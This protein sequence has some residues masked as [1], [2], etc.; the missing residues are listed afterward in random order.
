[1][2][3]FD[4]LGDLAKSFGEAAIAQPRF[5]WDIAQAPFN[6]NEEYNGFK[7]TLETAANNWTQSTL[8]FVGEVTNLPGIKQT[9]ETAMVPYR[10]YVAPAV[11][12]GLLAV[13][14]N[15]RELN[16]NLSGMDLLKK[17]FEEGK[18]VR[19]P[20]TDEF[21]RQEPVD[22]WRRKISPG[23]ALIADIAALIP[24]EQGADEVNWN[25]QESIENYYGQGLP[26]FFSGASDLGFS[27]LDPTLFLG[28]ASKAIRATDV[29]TNT[30]Q[31]GNSAAAVAAAANRK[32]RAADEI[33]EAANALHIASLESQRLGQEVA[34]LVTNKYTQLIK[35][36]TA[37]DNKYAL[38]QPFMENAPHKTTI[39]YALGESNDFQLTGQILAAVGVGDK[40]ALKALQERAEFVDIGNAI[41]RAQGEVD[42]LNKYLASKGQQTSDGQMTF[43]FVHES[44]A[45]NLEAK[46]ELEALK[47]RDA[48]LT[49]L[50]EA[51][52]ISQFTRTIGSSPVRAFDKFLAETRVAK[53]KVAQQN[54]ER[55][56]FGTTVTEY[57]PTPFH[58][59]I[60]V[61]ARPLD[62]RPAGH[63]NLNESD[64]LQ[65]LA[66]TVERG[67]KLAGGSKL[68]SFDA[69]VAG[70]YID[71]Y[72]NAQTPEARSAAVKAIERQIAIK[73]AQ[74]YG[75]SLEKAI[76][77]YNKHDRGRDSALVTIR[78]DTFII[79]EDGRQIHDPWFESQSANTLP[80]MD[81]DLFDSLLKKN[82]S[83]IPLLNDLTMQTV[84]GMDFL[85]DMFKAGALIRLGYLTR[86]TAEAQ[87]R[88][89]STLGAMTSLRHLGKGINNF[90]YNTT[91]NEGQRSIDRLTR[92]GKSPELA[93]LKT[94]LKDIDDELVEVEKT[95]QKYVDKEDLQSIADAKTLSTKYQELLE[96]RD[97]T[98]ASISQLTKP[99]GKKRRL[100]EGV[101][102]YE[103]LNGKKYYL[104]E[105]FA[106]AFG[107]L[108]RAE[109]S[110]ANTLTNFL[111]AN[112]DTIGKGLIDTGT[113]VV[114]PGAPGY[115]ENWAE[116]LTRQFGNSAVAKKLA[117]GE[118]P[119]AVV[120]WLFNTPEGRRVR[121]RLENL[122]DKYDA[123]DYVARTKNFLDR[124]AP[125]PEIQ[126]TLANP[127]DFEITVDMLKNKFGQLDE[128]KLP[129]IHGRVLEE[130]LNMKG[131][132]LIRV[133]IRKSFRVLGSLPED[134]WSRN[135]VFNEFYQREYT[136]RM[137][138][139]TLGLKP[140]EYV[141][142]KQV[143]MSEQ[144]ARNYALKQ[145]KKLLFTIDRRTNAAT[146]LRWMLPF[147]S[148]YVN[149]TRTWGRILYE[150]PGIAVRGYNLVTA[151]NR[152]GI[153]YDEEG[154]IVS[155]EQAT[156]DDSIVLHIPDGMKKLPIIGKG[157]ESL[158]EMGIQK[159]S[160]DVIMQGNIGLPVGPPI[161]IAASEVVKRKPEYEDTLRW[162]IPYGP[163]RNAAMAMIPAWAK[164]Q[165][166]KGM[167][168]DSPEYANTYELIWNTEQFKRKQ[169]GLPPATET[170]IQEMTDAFYNMRTV[171]NLVLPFAPR[172]NTPYKFYIDQYRQY[173]NLY[174]MDA[175]TKFFED[176]PEFFNFSTSLSKNNTGAA[177]TV[178]AVN[179]SKKYA[180]LI[181][182][183]R[184]DD[185]KL[186]GLIANTGVT[187]DFSR[188]AY[189][190]QQSNT[191]SP[192]SS[193]TF[194]G[195]NDPVQAQKETEA[196]LG[197]IKYRK[198]MDQIDAVMA[199]R[200]LT[201][202]QSK[203][204]ADLKELKRQLV[205]QLGKENE[206]WYDDYLDS[207]G[208]KTNR[209]IRGFEKIISNE[210]FM[211]DHGDN[212]TWKSLAI[213]LNVRRQVSDALVARGGT[214]ITNKQNA[215]LA[216]L[217]QD[218]ANQLKQQDIGFG[219]IYDRYLDS[220]R[221][222][223]VVYSTKVAE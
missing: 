108:Y 107:D 214:S 5:I 72:V 1:M 141:S 161:A 54:A 179:N 99:T 219:D 223:D 174:G 191:I 133:G 163:E 130:N 210:K 55:K 177:A 144:A 80:I 59:L 157:L 164:R 89:M 66:A 178:G 79:D 192:G 27:F 94:Q 139:L 140:N 34:P 92:I 166:V 132:N 136:R 58:K 14:P 222:Y 123:T 46:K 20:G 78:K 38:A 169:A 13:N 215:D 171:A 112:A 173:Q 10:D 150:N 180:D 65:E 124:Y 24:G 26:Q 216:A 211:N 190:W 41:A 74:K 90:I 184:A 103:G 148:A 221:V 134:S 88:I 63:I 47:K 68:G 200:G 37:N 202:L 71:E 69:E 186:I 168:Q 6:D 185:P 77:I 30:F 142:A 183:V 64:S 118:D 182:E 32:A 193:E 170:E 23:Q 117:A 70:K 151:P 206:A 110:S 160:L 11:G 149:T 155:S 126:K 120:K 172:F 82:K 49:D 83:S 208:S 100:F 18:T 212:P 91:K 153:A 44:D 105:G 60:Q 143:W 156:L 158:D 86:N 4:R 19:T 52:N 165:I 42:E 128:K 33:T 3:F 138:E 181:A 167:G 2:G 45:V 109:V 207:D 189:M 187:Y 104:N 48:M 106:G 15:Y 122:V 12:A 16:A 8:N 51:A 218:V 31:R 125:D 188:A 84:D 145:T 40:R 154:N 98:N 93:G 127:N 22:K 50:L 162:A 53:Y 119:E 35:D 9:L 201:N 56:I 176:Y 95:L 62:E 85:N 101:F 135:P 159:K 121:Y 220:D 115:W 29:V 81:F 175:K 213:Y 97:A 36:L 197:W 195:T 102:E 39:A 113:G 17:A 116:V 131:E 196:T 152:A 7:Q 96:L 205:Q 203:K 147:F 61:I 57:Q 217:L 198:V 75:V 194:R 73:I 204:A 114:K 25:S 209:A 76:E 87:L 137:D 21:G 43:E 111:E 129:I 199:A 146:T 67:T 28:K